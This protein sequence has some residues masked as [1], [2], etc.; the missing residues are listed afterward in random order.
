MAKTNH[1]IGKRLRDTQRDSIEGLWKR[2]TAPDGPDRVGLP[3]RCDKAWFCD[4]F[5]GGNGK[6]RSR[7]ESIWDL[8]VSFVMYDP[9]ALLCS[10]P[11]TRHFFCPVKKRVRGVDHLVIGTSKAQPGVHSGMVE[12]LRDFLYT[13]FFKGITMDYSEFIDT[14]AAA[15]ESQELTIRRQRMHNKVQP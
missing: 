8:V 10:V 5:C 11:A 14:Q 4:T 1:P 2:A 9:V 3:A 7:D 12:T 6:A 13:A 15:H